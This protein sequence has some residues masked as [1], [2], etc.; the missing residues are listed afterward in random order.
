MKNNLACCVLL[1]KFYLRGIKAV[2][3]LIVILLFVC[4]AGAAEKI[5]YVDLNRIMRQYPPF[6]SIRQQIQDYAEQKNIALA[7]ALAKESDQTKRQL[8]IQ[9]VQNDIKKQENGLRSIIDSQ[10]FKAV[11]K[12]AARGN[13][14]L[15]RNAEGVLYGKADL[16][17]EVIE[18]IEVLRKKAIRKLKSKSDET[19][20]NFWFSKV[21]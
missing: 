11:N 17:D 14:T 15:I 5:G 8:I 4:T 2:F 9:S 12:I 13:Y 3:A 6:V 10:I 19:D 7:N 16:T 18:E 21:V 1:R 20:R